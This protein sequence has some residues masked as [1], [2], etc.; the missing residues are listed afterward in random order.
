ME[1]G[2][3]DTIPPSAELTMDVSRG[4]TADRTHP[5]QFPVAHWSR[6]EFLAVL[7]HGGM[8][9]VYRAYDPQ[10]GRAVALKFIR[11]DHPNLPSRL[12]REAR[13][14]A[15]VD[16]PNI[17]KV[18]EVGE[19][20]GKA[21]IA[22]E[23]VAGEP[24]RADGRELSLH[25]KIVVVRD[26]ALALHEAHKLGILHRDIKPGNILLERAA[27]GRT[28][29]VVMD[30]GIARDDADA[31]QF[32]RTGA[33]LGTPAYM[34]PEQARGDRDLDRRTDVYGLGAT[35]YELL[36]GVPPFVA[37]T[38]V[39]VVLRVLHD[40]P[41]RLRSHAPKIPEDLETVVA[42]CLDKDPSRRY[43]SARA[44]ADDL[45]RWIRGEPIFGR[46]ESLLHHLLRRARKQRALVVVSL[47]ALLV[48]LVAAAHGITTRIAAREQAA[49]LAAE[50]E[51]ARELAQD[52]NK[53]EWLLRTAH[54]LPLHDTTPER[55][56]VRAR[57]DEVAARL[58]V[59]GRSAA[60]VEY[61]LGRGHLVLG[62]TAAAREHLTRALAGGLDTPELHYALGVALGDLYARELAELERTEKEPALSQRRAA[63]EAEYITPA[64]AAL[65]HARA[66]EI[67]APSHLAGLIALYR[68]DGDAAIDLARRARR[69]APW[70]YEAVVL[71]ARAHSARARTLT[72]AG[73]IAAA[74]DAAETAARL[75]DEAA[76][77][78]RSDAAVHLD[79]AAMWTLVLRD[80]VDRGDPR[81]AELL[82][83]ALPHVVALCESAAVTRP[84]LTRPFNQIAAAQTIR[85]KYLFERDRSPH[86]PVAAMI[87][88]SDR[89]LAI[90]PDDHEALAWRISA[91][92]NEAWYQL[93]IGVDPAAGLERA[94]ADAKALYARHGDRPEAHARLDRALLLRSNRNL[95]HNVDPT[96]DLAEVLGLNWTLA[97]QSD[98]ARPFD[99]LLTAYS[100]LA[101]WSVLHG[102]DPGPPTARSE[103]SFTRC[104]ALDPRYASCW[105]RSAWILQWH[106]QYAQMSGGDP[107]PLLALARERLRQAHDLSGP[108]SWNVELWL[109]NIELVD[110]A[111]RGEDLDPV[112]A[113]VDHELAAC[114]THSADCE[115]HEAELLVARAGLTARGDPRR[116]LLE[117][118][119]ALLGDDAGTGLWNIEVVLAEI[120]LGLATITPAARDR[121]VTAGLAATTRGLALAPGQ[122]RLLA[123]SAALHLLAAESAADPAARAESLRLARAAMARARAVHPWIHVEFAAT[124]A[125]L[126]R[127]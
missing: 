116:E 107:R 103:E 98:D 70:F 28:R 93:V 105:R 15:R 14:Q 31:E 33:L 63:L 9:T 18:F 106:A 26:C 113:R 101:Q 74:K 71:E 22:M 49:A 58:V 78:A 82:T 91:R 96:A 68:D 29:P 27:D 120:E 10:L 24:L 34:S 79:A 41:A 17:C 99:S 112:L 62:D 61:T 110:T 127:P 119:H 46:R 55:A 2:F 65:E 94:V 47:A 97:G 35:L 86:E 37:E 57:M 125:A 85:S 77:L 89:A 84:D 44:L 23:L 67:D 123:I 87:A 73:D 56:M 100:H 7:G 50:G 40:D 6:Y 108:T 115:V 30:F 92:L 5:D 75:A 36:A 25:D 117:R 95:Q 20:E 12:L 13:A 39:Q 118:A 88:A 60:L 53:V 72:R 48:V 1:P 43:D 114:R 66:A 81:A 54:L 109:L 16:H 121:H 124:L 19:V 90:D 80:H 102:Q 83:T 45:D 4:G 11:G 51:L 104:V 3:S 69:E 8:G 21:Y 76:A 32:T 122:P 64:L 126:D 52:T 42:K 59:P 38:P 111:R